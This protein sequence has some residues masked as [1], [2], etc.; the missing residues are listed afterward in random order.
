MNKRHQFCFLLVITTLIASCS[1]NENG[2]AL[3][4]EN[5]KPIKYDQVSYVG[6]IQEKSFSGTTQ[7]ASEADLSF[8]SSGSIVMLEAN[9]GNVVKKNQVLAKLDTKNASLRY[10]KAKSTERS[11]K[12]Q[13]ETSK[14]NL[15]RTKNLYQAG[16]FSLGDYENAKSN[17]ATALSN[18]ESAKK[19]LALEAIEF[20]NTKITSP[21]D[22]VVTQVNA[23]L[24]EYAQAGNPIIVVNGNDEGMEVNVGVPER[25]ITKLVAGQSVGITI[26]DLVLAGTIT[27]L[28]YS[29]SGS[30]TYPV[31][32]RLDE[33]NTQVRPGMSVKV[34]FRIDNSSNGEEMLVIPVSSVGD[35]VENQFVYT[36]VPQA[37]GKTYL[38][39]K[40]IVELGKVSNYGFE[41][42]SGLKEGDLVAVAGLRS[43]FDGKK[44]TLLKESK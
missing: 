9:V 1:G 39:Q 33:E 10:E 23:E 21:I 36:L 5:I 30:S 4:E 43:L 27:E 8:R 26:D 31:I 25:Y 42:L 35:D 44:V 3:S 32:V 17:Y 19:S 29:N 20:D 13:L 2:D 6:G 28:S 16:S 15:E 37:D 41:V 24:N 12:I 22:G 40:T 38:A 34:L 11:S 18:Y 14:S 7:S